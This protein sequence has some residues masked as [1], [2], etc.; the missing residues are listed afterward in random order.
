MTTVARQEPERHQHAGRDDVERQ[1]P[2][3]REVA[4]REAGVV[5]TGHQRREMK[6]P[7]DDEPARAHHEPKEA[8]E[9]KRGPRAVETSVDEQQ[10]QR[11]E[12]G[13]DETDHAAEGDA[14]R[15]ERG[16]ERDVADRTDEGDDGQY[17]SDRDVLQYRPDSVTTDEQMRPPA[18]RDVGHQEAGHDEAGEQFLT[19]HR[20]IP[21]GEARGE[22]VVLLIARPFAP[23]LGE[24]A[25]RGRRV[26][27]HPLAHR[28]L[29][30]PRED[31]VRGERQR[32]DHE[33]AA[34]E[35]RHDELPPEQQVQDDAQF[36]HQVRR[37]DHE[38]DRIR[39]RR[40]A[41]EERARHR[42]GGVTARRRDDA[43]H[44]GLRHGRGGSPSELGA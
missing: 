22:S 5:R 14:V 19:Q 10:G 27:Q 44:R 9:S 37:R 3:E 41:R 2:T 31:V 13:E 26:S 28:V 8:E 6:E 43:E 16:G 38:D 35:L 12:V 36:D 32:R 34:D 39:P 24:R 17:G 7:V 18:I 40:A 30:A 23:G 20:E 15:P 1:G 33:R 25:H 42:T 4:A 21:N 29:V 11:H